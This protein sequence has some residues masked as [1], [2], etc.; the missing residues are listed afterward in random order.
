MMVVSKKQKEIF[1]KNHVLKTLIFFWPIRRTLEMQF[2][3]VV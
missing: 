1:K 2:F 3:L